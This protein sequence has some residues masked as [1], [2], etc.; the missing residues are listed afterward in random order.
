MRTIELPDPQRALLTRLQAE[1]D[2]TPHAPWFEHDHRAVRQLGSAEDLTIAA[3]RDV[4]RALNHR[5]LLR[6]DREKA[7]RWIFR[8]S[9][10]AV[11]FTTA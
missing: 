8:V 1:T 3:D 2:A 4:L 10:S 9:P 11:E 7:P 5:G 6:F